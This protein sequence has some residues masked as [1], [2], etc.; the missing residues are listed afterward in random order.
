MNIKFY[1]DLWRH[2]MTQSSIFMSNLI[3]DIIQ[4]CECFIKPYLP[5]SASRQSKFLQ[6]EFEI[7]WKPCKLTFHMGFS[8]TLDPAT[9]CKIYENLFQ[10]K[11]FIPKKQ[12][13]FVSLN[14][15]AVAS[16][17]RTEQ[18]SLVSVK[19]STRSFFF[20]IFLWKCN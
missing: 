3:L 15:D 6:R 5:D 10:R 14:K 7:Q 19:K 4:K 17:Q 8:G 9:S 1:F 13:I 16:H 2:K 18:F 20:F 12:N 11:I